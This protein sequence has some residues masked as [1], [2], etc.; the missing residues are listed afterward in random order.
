MD[1]GGEPVAVPADAFEG[2]QHIA[3]P[4]ARTVGDLVEPGGRMPLDQ[5][6]P[7]RSPLPPLASPIRPVVQMA[8]G[9]D[10]R[11][12]PVQPK[13]IDP[14]ADGLSA[15]DVRDPL[16]LPSRGQLQIEIDR[17][18]IRRHAHPPTLPGN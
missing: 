4:P 17:A 1:G 2:D 7:D 9:Y 12:P 16:R 10:S 18:A 15:S 13:L 5:Q 8:A 3:Q 6:L 11:E 14:G